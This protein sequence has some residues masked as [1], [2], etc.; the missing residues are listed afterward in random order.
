MDSLT[1]GAK[2]QARVWLQTGQTWLKSATAKVSKATKEAGVALQK[3]F[4]DLDSRLAQK[5]WC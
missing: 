5:G 2:E 4:E 1:E 3:G